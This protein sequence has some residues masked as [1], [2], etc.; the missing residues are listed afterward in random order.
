LGALHML[1][2][3]GMPTSYQKKS[4]PTQQSV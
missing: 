4:G 1:T 2:L 3:L